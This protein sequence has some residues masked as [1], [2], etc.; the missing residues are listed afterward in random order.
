MKIAAYQFAV[1]SD[2]DKNFEIVLKAVRAAEGKGIEL[3]IFPECALTGY[4]PLDMESSLDVDF[5]KVKECCNKLQSLCDETGVAFILGTIAK[6]NDKIYNRAIFFRPESEQLTYDKRALWG[7]D[8]DNFSCKTDSNTNDSNNGE[9]CSNIR[10]KTEILTPGIVDYKG[11]RIGIRIC[12]EIR[13]PEYF[14]ELYRKQTDINVVLFYDVTD[15]E[16][17]DR[18]NM[19]K[20]HIQ[21]RAVE[22]VCTFITSNT[23]KPY[24]TAPTAIFGRS[25]QI[26][27]EC[28]R[29]KEAFVEYDLEKKEYDFGERG[30]KEISDILTD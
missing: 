27:A 17:T 16:N 22:N 21:T 7:W 23:I 20:G 9:C 2:I 15:E 30:R 18:Y 19:I 1:T 29:N 26:L 24:Q 12:F 6:E 4:P 13:F 25:G 14:R 3:V 5:S 28:P 8:R 11:F 10:K